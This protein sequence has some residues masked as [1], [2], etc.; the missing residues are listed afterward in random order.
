MLE[1]LPLFIPLIFGLTTALVLLLLFWILKNSHSPNVTQLSSKIIFGLAA[2]PLLT[3]LH[4]IRIPVEFVLYW[5]FL[6]QA[7][8]ELMT[9]AGRNF[10]IIAGITAPIIAYFGLKKHKIPKT[11]VLIWHFICLGLLLHIVVNAFLSAPSS[12]QK[13]AFDQPNIAILY[14]PFSGLP[15]FIVPVVLFCHL[16][17]IRQLLHRSN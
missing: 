11:V 15:T 7:V 14:F 17:A 5:L 6:S 2:W 3:Y 16:A 1:N 13:F 8:P 4:T 12:V 9:F 10:D